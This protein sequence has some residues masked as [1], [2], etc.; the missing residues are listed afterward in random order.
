MA[1]KDCPHCGEEVDKDDI[2]TEC[3]KCISC[4]DCI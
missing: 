3:S 1:S 2:C 4:C